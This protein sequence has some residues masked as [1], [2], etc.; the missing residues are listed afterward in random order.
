MTQFSD[1]G[2]GH[3][4]TSALDQLGYKTPSPIQLAAIP[5]ALAGHDLL[6]AAK[7]P[8]LC[9]PVWNALNVMPTPAHRLPCTLCVC[10]F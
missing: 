7:Q 4:I 8:L 2:L 9:Y 10:W 5:K 6:A 1:L 3:E